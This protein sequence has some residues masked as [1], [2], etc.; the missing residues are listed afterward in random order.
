MDATIHWKMCKNTY[1]YS[2]WDKKKKG[3]FS[4]NE[5]E[6]QEL[7]LPPLFFNAAW[8]LLDK[9]PGDFFK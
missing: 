8:N 6:S 3:L 7:V 2:I 5:L 4:S 9:L 1:K